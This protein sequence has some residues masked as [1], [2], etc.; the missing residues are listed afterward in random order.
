MNKKSEK[1]KRLLEETLVTLMAEKDF[2]KISIK[3]LTEK[4]DINRGTFYLHYKDKYDLLEQK[5]NSI[6]NELAEIIDNILKELPENFILPSNKKV[7]LSF[8]TSMYRYIKENANFMKILLG[9]N[10]DLNFQMKLK[11]FIENKL[12]ENLSPKYASTNNIHF[13]F[14]AAIAS[15][16]QIGIVEKWVKTDMK[17]TPEELSTFVSNIVFSI[18]NEVIKNMLHS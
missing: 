7:L 4:L 1:T 14:L 13:K 9:P 5:E 17:E 12:F 16:A 2:N 6:L 8:F 10:G 18:Y 11:N 3:D 15:S